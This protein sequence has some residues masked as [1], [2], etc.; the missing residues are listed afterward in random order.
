MPDGS[1]AVSPAL[2]SEAAIPAL[3]NWKDP[4]RLRK[5]VV[6]VN[7]TRE[8]TSVN[9]TP[10]PA[11]SWLFNALTGSAEAAWT[12]AAATDAAA[13]AAATHAII[14]FTVISSQ[15][16]TGREILPGLDHGYVSEQA[17]SPAFNLCGANP[18][19][20]RAT[21]QTMRG[22]FPEKSPSTAGTSRR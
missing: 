13:V 17:L 9:F 3:P 11:T 7:E 14:R 8:E 19:V 20:G 10:L 6:P 5:D 12:G 18:V 15:T 21:R 2:T 4:V 16:D 22:P 1:S